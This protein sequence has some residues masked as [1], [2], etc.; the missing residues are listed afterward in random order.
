VS[1]TIPEPVYTVTLDPG[2][3][4]GDPIVYRSSDQDEIPNWHQAQNCS[5]Y[6]EDNGSIGFRLEPGYCPESFSGNKGKIFDRWSD[7]GQFIALTSCE[8]TV[9]AQW[10]TPDW[11]FWPT[12]EAFTLVSGV[13][14]LA[15]GAED[16][17]SPGDPINGN[18]A[19][20]EGGHITWS[21]DGGHCLWVRL[22]SGTLQCGTNEIP[23]TFFNNGANQTLNSVEYGF[24]TKIDV[25]RF[26]V[27][28]DP[29]VVEAAPPGTY[30]AVMPL[31]CKWDNNASV[32]DYDFIVEMSLTLVV[33]WIERT[34]TFNA[35]G[36]TVDP[37]SMQTVNGR[38]T[39]LPVPEYGEGEF[40]GWFTERV[41]GE[42]VGTA[43][44]FGSD[45]TVY[46]HY[47]PYSGYALFLP[48][49]AA[50]DPDGV[51]TEASVDLSWLEF[52]EQANGQ[53]P[54][55][56]RVI[57]E[58]G[59][60][61]SGSGTI[62]FPFKL[63]TAAS[64]A[65]AQDRLE[66]D[67]TAAGSPRSIWFCIGE[68]DR[69]GLPAGVYS[70]VLTCTVRWGYE[71]G[72]WSEDLKTVTVPVS[73]EITSAVFT[74]TLLPGDCVGEP[75]VFNSSWQSSFP[76]W[77]DAQNCS[78][79]L[80]DDGRMGFKMDSDYLPDSFIGINGKVFDRWSS[81]DRYFTLTSYETTVTALWKMSDT[82]FIPSPDEYT[83]QSGVNSL[84]LGAQAIVDN[85]TPMYS[86]LDSGGHSE[87]FGMLA[88]KLEEGTL[89]CGT[90]EIDFRLCDSSGD[91]A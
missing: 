23:F 46:A 57:F 52:S 58:S 15:F 41:G 30:T 81:T 9:T 22:E 89:K 67:W 51:L 50:L 44:L 91:S 86:P 56:L 77:R 16:L 74:F 38:L 19:D 69:D 32:N 78:F 87:Y 2:D 29:D 6:Y 80:E 11:Y 63:N 24:F 66:M 90:N 71:N 26:S 4:R 36:G 70:G 88:V 65:G 21:D 83:L 62:E 34:V 53:T 14:D 49:E 85:G 8:T 33:T 73:L 37:S 60:L 20:E 31:Y 25:F 45:T 1:L 35:Q 54:V 10:K 12:V 27:Y 61:Q 7:P 40:L 55:A 76:G 79:Y 39:A 48:E 47:R 68:D 42:A 3:G 17:K 5:F 18:D 43:T 28:V 75:I 72:T 84:T 82:Y 59:K 64:A 13:N